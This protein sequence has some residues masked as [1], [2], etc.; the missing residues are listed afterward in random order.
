MA[1][2]EEWDAGAA[3]PETIRRRRSAGRQFS[4]VPTEGAPPNQPAPVKPSQ[5]GA[6]RARAPRPGT[7][8]HAAAQERQAKQAAQKKVDV[9]QTRASV[10][11]RTN[12]ER[13][14]AGQER[15][16]D[17]VDYAT[18]Q[19]NK[20]ARER[21]EL[22]LT[23]QKRLNLT[24]RQAYEHY[25]FGEHHKP[26]RSTMYD[27]QL[28]GMEDPQ[29]RP[30]PKRWEEHTPE[31]QARTL[32]EVK[33]LGGATPESMERSFGAQL[34]QGYLRARSHGA[35]DPYAQTFYTHGEAAQRL[36]RSATEH[37]TSLG[38]VA[39]VNA[40]TSPNMKFK[41]ES[42]KTGKVSYPNAELAD[43]I[44]RHISA[45]K[46]PDSWSKDDPEHPLTG[47][48]RS[49]YPA[50]AAKA[51]ERAHQVIRQGKSIA[52]TDAGTSGKG[53]FGPKTGAYH[54]AWL[55]GTPQFFV[56]DIHSGGGGMLPH[57]G[58]EKPILTDPKGNP[59]LLKSGKPMREKSRREHVIEYASRQSNVPRASFHALSDYVARQ[60]MA[61]RGLTHVEQAQATQWGEETIRRHETAS[62]AG[63]TKLAANFPSEH[64][65]YP[66]TKNPRQFEQHP[67]QGRLF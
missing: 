46:D 17:V 56:S 50:N 63:K 54:N 10:R 45:G 6:Q 66:P 48:A 15:T 1:A 64:Q 36:Q 61:K 13:S 51:L 62:A 12:W 41:Y 49:G 38:L 55:G 23:E 44:I 67:G 2:V 9:A 31:E 26:G 20:L 22:G 37:G 60:A 47:H 5:T 8:A 57:L 42:K 21:P 14:K 7:K 3:P 35:D 52:E 65:A 11:K 16:K 27:Q 29:A 4:V 18:E 53:G 43:H 40:D 25:G 32:E 19:H 34:D 59:R 30:R 33:R 28:P 58:T 24:P 39:A